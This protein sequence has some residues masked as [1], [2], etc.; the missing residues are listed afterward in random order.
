MSI[1]VMANEIPFAMAVNISILPAM[2]NTFMTAAC[3]FIASVLPFVATA[4]LSSD[5]FAP[6]QD[7]T[8][9]C[10]AGLASS[11]V[12]FQ[13]ACDVAHAS[14]CALYDLIAFIS[15]WDNAW[16]ANRLPILPFMPEEACQS[17]L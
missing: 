4:S 3:A 12:L 17:A 10:A 13:A 1:A 7:A 15:D 8:R 9:F 16:D 6:L 5:T 11:I 14:I 2:D